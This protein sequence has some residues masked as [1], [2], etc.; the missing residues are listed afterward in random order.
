MAQQWKQKSAVPRQA[1]P[2]PLPQTTALKS[3][4]PAA[5]AAVASAARSQR[6]LPQ[7]V[8]MVSPVSRTKT[9]AVTVARPVPRIPAAPAALRGTKAAA[10][11]ASALRRGHLSGRRAP[12]SQPAGLHKSS[13]QLHSA[14][15]A[16]GQAL[17]VPTAAC[18]G[19]QAACLTQ[20]VF[21]T[22]AA[23]VPQTGLLL[24][25]PVYT[26]FQQQALAASVQAMMTPR[27]AGSATRAPH[28][29]AQL[30]AAVQLATVAYTSGAP[31]AMSA[32][33]DAHDCTVAHS[34]APSDRV[35]EISQGLQVPADAAV[36]ASHT[37]S[38]AMSHASTGSPAGAP[39]GLGL[40]SG[41]RQQPAHAASRAVAAPESPAAGGDVLSGMATSK[42]QELA[43]V[44][45]PG[46]AKAL[47]QAQPAVGQH[48]AGA[49]GGS[50]VLDQA[51]LRQLAKELVEP[52]Q[53]VLKPASPQDLAAAQQRPGLQ[54]LGIHSRSFPAQRL[55]AQSGPRPLPA[56]KHTAPDD[57]QGSPPG[58][59][60]I[61]HPPAK[62]RRVRVKVVLP[63]GEAGALPPSSSPLHRVDLP[64]V[65]NANPFKTEDGGAESMRWS[66]REVAR[67][68]SGG[69]QAD[70]AGDL[71][72]MHVSQQRPTMSIGKDFELMKLVAL[73]GACLK[74]LAPETASGLYGAYSAQLCPTPVSAGPGSRRA[75]MRAVHDRGLPN[76]RVR[77]PT[78]GYEEHSQWHAEGR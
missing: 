56:V 72:Y 41:L 63:A 7:G 19:L 40:A 28:V 64:R 38:A 11:A 35:H 26:P 48:A 49:H 1:P 45:A 50:P 69:L 2:A 78:Q 18:T 74:A 68:D 9:P 51:T 70:A 53:N 23:A 25:P 3:V 10:S 54:P 77:R 20:G 27:S 42:V 73:P 65:Q 30:R 4:S 76:G 36:N 31:A 33:P 29:M 43:Q 34:Q 61:D 46:V 66:S 58:S 5:S 39:A 44:M 6:P 52:V 21:R 75:P 62:K 59:G 13:A 67:K 37:A 8:K 71:P 17:P 15:P 24:P 57:A 47:S 55:L 60:P 12:Y 22:G 32:S 14:L 16:S